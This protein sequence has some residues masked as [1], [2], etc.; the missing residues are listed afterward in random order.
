MLFVEKISNLTRGNLH[1]EFETS[2]IFVVP[3]SYTVSSSSTLLLVK[4]LEH[5]SNLTE[6]KLD[7]RNVAIL[8]ES[9]RV[10]FLLTTYSMLLSLRRYFSHVA[11]NLEIQ[12]FCKRSLTII[13]LVQVG[14]I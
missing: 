1:S 10:K 6:R 9:K 7:V 13:P 5:I 4:R 11:L 3:S 12:G 2:A 8:Q 14:S